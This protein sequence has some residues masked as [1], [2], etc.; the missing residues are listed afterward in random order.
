MKYFQLIVIGALLIVFPVMLSAG[1]LGRDAE[2]FKNIKRIELKTTSASC[3]VK[4]SE[5]ENVVVRVKAKYSPESNV[6]FEYDVD[7]TTLELNEIIHGSSSGNASFLLA[8]P[9][10]IKIEFTSASGE[11]KV[12]DVD[13]DFKTALASGNILIENSD[14]I[15]NI[16]T[17]SGNIDAINVQLAGRSIFG[18]ASG[19]SKVILGASPKYDIKV[20][21]A[22][23]SAILDFNENP[24]EG[25]IEMSCK[26][27]S[28]RIKAPMAFDETDRWHHEGS[29]DW[30]VTKSVTVGDRNAPLI[31]VGTASGSATLR[32]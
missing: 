2:I 28:G 21:S 22:S 19:R 8:V 12:V 3:I 25:Y 27:R 30:Y 6:S 10:N 29:R 13:G 9:D 7:R 15:F 24:I 5:D 23:G 17:A 11:L 32:E 4:P 14:G 31:E 18:T 1:E 20:G 16:N 26:E